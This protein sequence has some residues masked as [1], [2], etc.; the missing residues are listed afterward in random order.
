M[1]K[2]RLL[3][4]EDSK[5][6]ADIICRAAYE[7][8]FEV[9]SANGLNAPSIYEKFNPDIIVL[10]ILMPELDGLEFLRFLHEQNSRAR[11]IIL[12]G[13]SDTYRRMA[14]SIGMASGLYI[15]ANLAK[16]FRINEVRSA[17]DMARSSMEGMRS[18][19]ASGK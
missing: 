7:L 8:D 4:I 19:A 2:Y 18:L 6:I 5:N 11:I 9:S 10:D 12:S 15:E 1:S 14:E 13:S 3:V 16:P 17:L